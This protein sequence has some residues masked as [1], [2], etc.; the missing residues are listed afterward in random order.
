M[1]CPSI[2]CILDFFS[3]L[4]LVIALGVEVLSVVYLGVTVSVA[5]GVV[6]QD[7]SSRVFGALVFRFFLAVSIQ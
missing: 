1:L 6:A 4:L 3:S 5:Q 7:I 2:I